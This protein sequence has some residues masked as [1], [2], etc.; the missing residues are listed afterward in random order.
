M[1]QSKDNLLEFLK[2][3]MEFHQSII[4]ASGNMPLVTAFESIAEYHKYSQ[5]FSSL[6]ESEV[7]TAIGYHRKMLFA[8]KS[9]NP[10]NGAKAITEH[11]E[12]TEQITNSVKRNKNISI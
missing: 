4:H 12:H 1:E 7:Q 9:R 3:D 6:Y 10:K 2:L 5:V 11:L 8:L